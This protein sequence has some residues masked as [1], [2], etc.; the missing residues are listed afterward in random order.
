MN[1]KIISHHKQED[2]T[3]RTDM[4]LEKEELIPGCT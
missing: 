3:I 2:S 1:I 4:T